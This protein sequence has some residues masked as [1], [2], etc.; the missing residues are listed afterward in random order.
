MVSKKNVILTILSYNK[1]YDDYTV[2]C[3]ACKTIN[4]TF[5][6]ETGDNKKLYSLDGLPC[7]TC[8]MI[9]ITKI[10]KGEK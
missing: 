5:R 1:K 7:K 6:T 3:G 4:A 10:N 8:G 2:R 9:M